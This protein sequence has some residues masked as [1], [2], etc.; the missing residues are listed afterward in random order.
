MFAFPIVLF[1]LQLIFNVGKSSSSTS[2][3]FAYLDL[4]SF[5]PSQ[6]VCQFCF[7]CFIPHLAPC[8]SFV[9]Q[10][11]FK[12]VLFLIDKH[13]FLFP[14][15][16]GSIYCTLFL[17]DCFHIAHGC[18]SIRVC[19]IILIIIC[20]ILWLPFVWG[21][22]LVSH[23]WIFVFISCNAITNHVWNLRSWPEI[24]P[25]AFGVQHWLQDPRLPES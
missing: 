15:F 21:S 23:F 1:P 7:H 6:H 14:L 18:I 3:N 25:G 9:F 4:L 17:L 13:N 2:N 12:L 11:V 22:S 5:L 10:F 24:K 20:L 8:F 16:A 19:F